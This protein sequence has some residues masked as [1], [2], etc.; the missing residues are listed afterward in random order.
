MET[1]SSA[2]KL[3][4]PLESRARMA[5]HGAR[6]SSTN[7]AEGPEHQ[8]RNDTLYMCHA[9]TRARVREDGPDGRGSCRS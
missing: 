2:Q 9:M 5:V 4:Q 1:V 6:R 8:R 7:Y 3:G